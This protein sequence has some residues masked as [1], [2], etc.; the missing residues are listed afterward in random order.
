MKMQDEIFKIKRRYYDMMGRCNNPNLRNYKYYGAR[1]IKVCE[2]W[3]GK[4]GK[5]NFIQWALKS[6][7]DSN[8]EL[9]RIDNNGEYSPQNCRWTDRRTQ[10][11]NKRPSVKG[12]TGFV[13]ISITSSSYDSHIYY[14]GRVKDETGKAKYTGTS[15]DIM[16]AVKMRNEYILKHGLNNKLNEI[17][18]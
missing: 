14:Y 1:G 16:K 11:I 3:L 6:G 18:D 15:S 17:G 9:D 5:E 7:F 2:E 10:N 8:L 12:K 13:G 4:Q